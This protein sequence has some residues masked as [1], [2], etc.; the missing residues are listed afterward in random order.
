[1]AQDLEISRGVIIGLLIMY[2]SR[3]VAT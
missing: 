2:V 3:P 1:M